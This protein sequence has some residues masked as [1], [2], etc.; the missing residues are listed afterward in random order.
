MHLKDNRKYRFWSGISIF[1]S[2]IML[3]VMGVVVSACGTEQQ[4]TTPDEPGTLFTTA[5]V[6]T[7]EIPSPGDPDAAPG[8]V[9]TPTVAT[10]VSEVPDQSQ[11]EPAESSGMVEEAMTATAVPD[12]E[13]ASP[14]PAT[15]TPSPTSTVTTETPA[16]PDTLDVPDEAELLEDASS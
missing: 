9:S 3:A 12:Q 2:M 16:E 1:F 14:T 11:E 10:P 13:Q 5:T 6:S 8:I 15:L 7:P 4:T